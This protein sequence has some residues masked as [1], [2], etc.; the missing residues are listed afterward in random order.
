MASSALLIE[1]LSLKVPVGKNLQQGS[2]FGSAQL[3]LSSRLSRTLPSWSGPNHFG[4][5]LQNWGVFASTNH[6][7]YPDLGSNTFATSF[8]VET[9]GGVVVSR[10]VG[11]FLKLAKC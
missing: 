7:H 11:C 9:S 1:S 6:K 3:Y 5:L 4:K 8:H 10:N 2:N